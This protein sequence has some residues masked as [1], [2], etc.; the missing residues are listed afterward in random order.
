MLAHRLAPEFE[1][2]GNVRFSR[3]TERRCIDRVRHHC[4]LPIRMTIVLDPPI[5]MTMSRITMCPVD[6]ATL[7][8][9][10]ILAVE[11]DQISFLHR[12]HT[13]CQIDIVSHEHCLPGCQANDESLMPAAGIVIGKDSRDVATAL[14][15]SVAASILERRC[16][17]L[18]GIVDDTAGLLRRRNEPGFSA[19][20]ICGCQNETY[21]DELLHLLSPADDNNEPRGHTGQRQRQSGV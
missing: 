4:A 14:N 2:E 16:Q 19:A 8:I 15:L 9:P 13:I 5:Y 18:V 3:G 12:G 17:C 10:L 1:Q 21:E 6:D 11:L 20:E 7:R